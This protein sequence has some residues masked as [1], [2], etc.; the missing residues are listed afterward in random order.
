MSPVQEGIAT[1]STDHATLKL[2]CIV[3][4]GAN[5]RNFI[6]G[7][8]KKWLCEHYT[9]TV[10]EPTVGNVCTAVGCCTPVTEIVFVNIEFVNKLTKQLENFKCFVTVKNDL[11]V[12]CIIRLQT[13]GDHHLIA[14]MLSLDNTTNH[15]EA[16][17][18]DID[19]INEVDLDNRHQCTINSSELRHDVEN[20]VHVIQNSLLV[21]TQPCGCR[22]DSCELC[23]FSDAASESVFGTVDDDNE[24]SADPLDLSL[25]SLLH[26]DNEVDASGVSIDVESQIEIVGSAEFKTTMTSLGIKYADIFAKSVRAKPANM[27]PLTLEVDE[28]KLNRIL[29]RCIPRPQSRE[30]TEELRRMVVEFTTCRLY[31]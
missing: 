14:K 21:A 26:R 8:V 29:G 30:K 23:V 27:K 15:S 10:I 1:S 20:N 16:P 5:K 9:E 28:L 12:D 7:K 3:D 19:T 11:A 24:S 4:T 22:G 25:E 31:K 6:S 13:I 17:V 18:Y 2:S